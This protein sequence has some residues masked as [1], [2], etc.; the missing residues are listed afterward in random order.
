MRRQLPCISFL[1]VL[2]RPASALAVTLSPT[3][4]LGLLQRDAGSCTNSTFLPCGDSKLPSDF[5]C[6]LRTRCISLDDSSSALCCPDGQDCA[7]I[8]PIPCNVQLQ[9][10]KLHPDS[11]VKTSKLNENL[12]Q[13]GNNCCPRGY[14]CQD[15][16][17]CIADKPAS[18]PAQSSSS[19]S[20][21]S[22]PSSTSSSATVVSVSPA[23]TS[24]IFTS[25]LPGFNQTSA[26]SASL[27]SHCPD[28]PGK[29]IAAGF[30]SGLFCGL[31]I[32]LV[33]ILCYKHRR[34]VRL[35]SSS[36]KLGHL[37][38]RSSDELIVSISDPIPSDSQGS[39]RTD[40]LRHTGNSQSN[41]RSRS[42]NRASS[43]V[44]SFFGA[45]PTTHNA[46]P[47]P[48]TPPNQIYPRREPSTESIKVYS[49]AHMR[50]GAAGLNPANTARTS[51]PQ[52]TFTEIMERVGFQNSRGSPY[53]SVTDTPQSL[54]R[55]RP[56][57]PLK[58]G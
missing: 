46:P 39:F 49:P 22:S 27:T 31:G 47:L 19:A 14:T 26:S 21:I 12:P 53:F 48:V 25:A 8:M 3:Q 28:F 43:R 50:N 58:R 37:R 45:K 17:R 23:T 15:N 2:L 38:Q 10:V 13:C 42:K 4:A 35:S 57:S 24:P 33:A 20:S 30:F 5:C 11:P 56:T 40:F 55:Q 18:K 36:S 6:P 32:A 7:S 44:R 1:C 16:G 54:P 41:E 51:R 9:N 34:Q 29:A 52:T